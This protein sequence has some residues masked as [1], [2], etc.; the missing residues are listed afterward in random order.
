M[1]RRD[2]VSNIGLTL[3]LVCTAGLAACSKG[4]SND[5]GPTPPG[6]GNAKLT[7]N[8]GSDLTNVGDFRISNGVIIIRTGSGNTASAF[9]ALSS[10]CTHQGCT[11]ATFNN[12]SKLIECNAPCGHGSRYT[13]TGAV[14]TGPATAALTAYTIKVDGNVLTVS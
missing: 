1:E 12:T 2:F 7:L 10:T 11:V 5:P 13:T 6:G 4:G 8:L 9:T 14:N 3:A